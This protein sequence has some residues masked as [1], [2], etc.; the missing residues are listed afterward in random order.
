M[1]TAA[2]VMLNIIL[3]TKKISYFQKCQYCG[4]FDGLRS[5]DHP[6]FLAFCGKCFRCHK[7][8]KSNPTFDKCT[9]CGQFDGLRWK[10]SDVPIF[11]AS[12][13]KCKAFY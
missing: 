13:Q 2:N 5:Y 6:P 1:L 3:E 12:C 10:K 11:T 4:Q 7:T 8:H 9:G